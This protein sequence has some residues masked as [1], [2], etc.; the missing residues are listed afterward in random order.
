MFSEPDATPVSY[1]PGTTYRVNSNTPVLN[2]K[3]RDTHDL[4][5]ASFMVVRQNCEEAC[6]QKILEGL[7]DERQQ[8]YRESSKISQNS[9][10]TIKDDMSNNLDSCIRRCF[11][12]FRITQ[13][14]G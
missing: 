11:G 5:L 10:K 8:E 1:H 4:L 6:S 12:I 2:L 3:T 7:S 14:K 9:I 13:V